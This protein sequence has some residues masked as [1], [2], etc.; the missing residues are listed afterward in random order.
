MDRKEIR[1]VDGMLIGNWFRIVHFLLHLSNLWI[2]LAYYS[3]GQI[4]TKDF[5]TKIICQYQLTL[6]SSLLRTQLQICHISHKLPCYKKLMQA[7]FLDLASGLCYRRSEEK[8]GVKGQGS[9]CNCSVRRTTVT[10]CN[11]RPWLTHTHIRSIMRT[12][13]FLLGKIRFKNTDSTW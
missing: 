2:V 1:C 4:Y 7:I 8:Y 11:Y 5:Q 9:G 6:S 10:H 13:Q 3:V 12:R